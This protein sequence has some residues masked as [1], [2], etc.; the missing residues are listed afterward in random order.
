MF[1]QEYTLWVTGY[2]P[3]PSILCGYPGICQSILCGYPG[4]CQSILCAYPRTYPSTRYGLKQP[5]LVPR[6]VRVYTKFTAVPGYTTAVYAAIINQTLET[7]IYGTRFCTPF[8]T[9]LVHATDFNQPVP[10]SLIHI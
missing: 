8:P 6:Y 4:I 5:G 2:L 3:Y 10:L 7:N 1:S 9:L